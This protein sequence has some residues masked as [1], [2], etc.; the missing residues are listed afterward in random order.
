MSF[1]ALGWPART[2]TFCRTAKA[3]APPSANN[4]AAQPGKAP[5]SPPAKKPSAKKPA[6]KPP[7]KQPVKPPPPPAKPTPQ[8]Q[9][10]A[11]LANRRGER[12]RRALH[13]TTIRFI[14]FMDM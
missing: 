14:F 1:R 6:R 11:E 3:P 10:Q 13:V 8:L 9:R 7:A 12:S 4:A 5:A 2:D